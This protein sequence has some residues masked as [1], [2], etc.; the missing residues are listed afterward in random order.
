MNP[1]LP[2]MS[3]L[4]SR[5]EYVFIY[6]VDQQT[7]YI[8]H[9]ARPLPRPLELEV[10]VL[11]L[12]R[13]LLLVRLALPLA[14]L[15]HHRGGVVVIVVVVVAATA[16][17]RRTVLSEALDPAAGPSAR[18]DVSLVRPEEAGCANGLGLLLHHAVELRREAVHAGRVRRL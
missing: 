4:L 14:C 12:L 3:G 10:P 5:G 7:D 11:L 13:I 6:L 15:L 8:L 1:H 2:F 9:F 16:N 17:A 18:K